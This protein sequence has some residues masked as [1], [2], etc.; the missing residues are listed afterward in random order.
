[1]LRIDPLR[2]EHLRAIDVVRGHRNQVDRH[3]IRNQRQVTGETHELRRNAI[4][5]EHQTKPSL[6]KTLAQSI[7]ER[8]R[9]EAPRLISS[10]HEVRECCVPSLRQMLSQYLRLEVLHGQS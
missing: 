3:T 10:L 8:L 7:V 4:E 6:S 9:F 1:M 2:D 5:D